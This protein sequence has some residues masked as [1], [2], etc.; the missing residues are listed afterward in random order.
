MPRL[1]SV[2]P[3]PVKHEQALREMLAQLPADER[4]KA[5][6]QINDLR[7]SRAPRHLRDH[8]MPLVLK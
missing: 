4:K 1:R 8:V 3:D 5:L 6:R 7:V 2:L